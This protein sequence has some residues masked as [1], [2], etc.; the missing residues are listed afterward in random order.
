[1]HLLQLNQIDLTKIIVHRYSE[2]SNIIY[3]E[4]ALST[5]NSP[6]HFYIE[7]YLNIQVNLY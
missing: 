1:M 5:T 3:S 7:I 6:A 4:S 2:F